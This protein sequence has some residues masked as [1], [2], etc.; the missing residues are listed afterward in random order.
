MYKNVTNFYFLLFYTMYIN[1]AFIAVMYTLHIL[2]FIAH[3]FYHT[4]SLSVLFFHTAF[5]CLVLVSIILLLLIHNGTEALYNDH[6]HNIVCCS[7]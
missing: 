4:C 1:G 3:F 2:P 6:L 7:L 5:C